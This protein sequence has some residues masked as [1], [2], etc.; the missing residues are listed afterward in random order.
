MG[1]LFSIFQRKNNTVPLIS[2]RNEVYFVNNFKYKS[3]EEE[4]SPPGYNDVDHYYDELNRP[5]SFTLQRSRSL[6][7]GWD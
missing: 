3:D 6:H 2:P 4:I 7:Y 5:Y 1:C